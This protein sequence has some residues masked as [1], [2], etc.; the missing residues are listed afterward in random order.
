VVYDIYV[1]GKLGVPVTIENVTIL[2]TDVVGSTELSQRLS[3]EGADEVRRRHFSILRQ[4]IVK[5]GGAEV[6]N[7]GDGLMVV[8]SSASAALSCG[9]GMQQGVERDNRDR[10]QSVGLRVG[11]SGGEVT[12]EET[13]YF[14][15]PVIEAAR[16]C[17]ICQG[18]QILAADVVRAMAGRRSRHSVVDLGPLIL[19]G[20]PDPVDTVEV[21]WEPL[22]GA[23]SNAVPL[24]A[25][26]A[27]RP[28]VGVVGREVELEVIAAAIKRGTAAES[29]QVLLVSGEAGVGKTTL[30][31]ESVRAAFDDGACVLFGHCEE[32]LVTPYRLFAEAL[33]H[34]VTHASE[35]QLLAHVDAHSERPSTS[36]PRCRNTSPS[37]LSLTTFSGPT[38]EV[39]CS[40]VI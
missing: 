14:G 26:L 4:A 16:L 35:E 17:A 29:R 21:R 11:L 25:R 8:F 5:A 39:C 12:R 28:S 7:L 23:A 40:C 6:K 33:E 37:S 27:A 20:L 38:R 15:D 30:V 31:S 1:L 18:G 22:G 13:D 24:P 3:P 32:D 2:F 9:V 34:Y 10:E 19:R 36:W